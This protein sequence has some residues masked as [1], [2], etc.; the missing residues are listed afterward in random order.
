MV[1]TLIAQVLASWA[2]LTV[3]VFAV[4]L[5]DDIGVS[6]TWIGVY[7]SLTY[8]SGMVAA[9]FC[10]PFI[11]R[12]GA[13]RVSQA[14]LLI[15]ALSLALLTAS[16]LPM[17][18]VCAL[19]MGV[20]YGPTTP[21]SSHILSA[22]TPA[23]LMPLIFSL[24]QTGVP[25]GGM[26]AGA[27][28][29]PL[30]LLYGWQGTALVVAALAA[31]SV[32]LLQPLRAELDA[33][34]DPAQ[35]LLVNPF[36]AIGMVWRIPGLRRMALLSTA[37]SA[38]QMCLLSYLVTYMV[39]DV[40]RDLVTGGLILATAQM[41][42]VGGRVLW[43]ALSGLW[44]TA[45]QVLIL[46]G[47]LI[48]ACGVAMALVTPAW[49]LAGL[50]AVAAVYGATAISWN[51]VQL[52]ELSRLAPPGQAVMATSGSLFFTFTGVMLGPTLFGAWVTATGSYAA[53]FFVLAA[54]GLVGAALLV[55][56]YDDRPR[57]S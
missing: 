38:V 36:Y 39:T 11:L 55:K 19:I 7:V 25:L 50:F 56:R 23:R 47:L 26:L 4:R 6:A 57:D 32:F 20:A 30:V 14:C 5:A 15:A 10:G 33:D 43:G 16:T 35:R 13:I 42:G 28:V 44:M 53:G 22:Q 27:L 31:A 54:L 41:A 12:F 29:P 40:G 8:M 9:I 3:P 17:A 21:A 51:G 34:R 48:A 46:L 24:K 18:I 2:N 49:P 52:A 45:R 37:F 1:L